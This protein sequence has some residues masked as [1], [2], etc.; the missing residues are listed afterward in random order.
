MCGS[1]LWFASLSRHLC[2]KQATVQACDDKAALGLV[3]QHKVRGGSRAV[4]LTATPFAANVAV[5]RAG[6]CTAVQLSSLGDLNAA[7]AQ[8]DPDCLIVDPARFT[9]AA[10]GN[11]VRAMFKHARTTTGQ[12]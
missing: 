12:S 1:A 7:L 8:A 6:C 2:P 9:V 5:A 11:L 4:W 10:V 3:Q